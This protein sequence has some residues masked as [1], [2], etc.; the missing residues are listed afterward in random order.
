[1]RR[2]CPFNHMTVMFRKTE[3]LKAGNYQDWY[4]NEDYFLWIRMALENEKFAN[5]A[6]VLVNVR[7]SRDL[8]Q[9]RGGIKYFVSER[10]IQKLMLEEKMIGYFRYSINVIERAILQVFIGVLVEA[11][12]NENDIILLH[13]NT[14]YPTPDIIT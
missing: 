13:C 1:M 7:T 4:W 3:V 14:E 5:L 9:R 10:K 8:Y 6:D 11:G 12:T 2:R